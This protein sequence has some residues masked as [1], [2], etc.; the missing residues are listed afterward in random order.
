MAHRR[1]AE[2]DARRGARDAAFGE[3][4]IERREKVQVEPGQID[5]VDGRDRSNRLEQSSPRDRLPGNGSSGQARRTE[6]RRSP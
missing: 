5:V 3:Q 4:G 6:A 2:A 1:L